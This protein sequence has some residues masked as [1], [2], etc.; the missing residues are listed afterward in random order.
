MIETQIPKKDVLRLFENNGFDFNEET[1]ELVYEDERGV[2]RGFP[3]PWLKDDDTALYDLGSVRKLLGKMMATVKLSQTIMDAANDKAFMDDVAAALREFGMS[4]IEPENKDGQED[5]GQVF[6]YDEPGVVSFTAPLDY[7][8]ATALH[9][10]DEL[11][12]VA[13]QNKAEAKFDKL[14]TKDLVLLVLDSMKVDALESKKE[15]VQNGSTEKE[16]EV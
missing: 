16:Q 11:E 1:H 8:V 10:R 4:Y 3:L 13:K 5:Q 12:K 7:I 6:V 14:S 2:K 15:K 9:K